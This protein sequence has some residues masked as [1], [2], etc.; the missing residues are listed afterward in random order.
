MQYDE[1]QIKTIGKRVENGLVYKNGKWNTTLYTADPQT[2]HPSGSSGYST[3]LYILTNDGFVIERNSPIPGLLDTS[4]FRHIMAFQ[5]PQNLSI[6]TNETW[7]IYSQPITYNKKNV[8]VIMTAYY[9]PEGSTLSSIDEKLQRTLN[10]LKSKITYKNGKIDVTKIDIRQIDYDVS[11][12]V[13]NEFNKVLLNNG[14]MPTYIDKSYIENE[15]KLTNKPRVVKTDT[16]SYLIYSH[17]IRDE[18]NNPVGLILVGKSINYIHEIF[19]KYLIIILGITILLAIILFYVL[20]NAVNN[21]LRSYMLYYEQ[22]QSEKPMPSSIMFN[23]QESYIDVDGEKT[24]IPYAS[25]Q[26]Y[27]CDAFFS[28]P[29]K[30]W[31]QDELLDK[32]GEIEPEHHWRKVYDAAHAI[33]KK[34]G[35]KLIESKD[36]IFRINPEILPLIKT[37]PKK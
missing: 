26:Y 19:I 36:R 33:N 15:F 35:I 3:P 2:P 31:E 28:N 32:F 10:G 29:H 7:R 14:R 1:A 17:E 18:H 21:F 30:R 37:A 8:G 12:E 25:N 13:V 20:K 11:F 24:D 27:L 22:L 9:N 6:T 23:K 16:T 5:T 4:D 34:L